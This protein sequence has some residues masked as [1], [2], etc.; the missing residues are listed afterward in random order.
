M[1]IFVDT[2]AL[3]AVLDADDQNHEQAKHIWVDLIT[4]EVDLICTNYVLLEICALVQ[5][6]LGM[7]AV[8]IFQEDVVPILRLEWVTKVHHAAG[9]TALLIAADRQLNLVDC[10]SFETMRRL[11]I[12][13][14]FVFDRHFL[15]QGF[16]CI[17]P[18]RWDAL[19]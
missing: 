6:R 4:Q 8:R 7:E 16:E 2:S 17:P 1:S 19:Q 11:G 3:F 10:V 18:G 12:K 14:A 13:K 15:E 5:R 9:M